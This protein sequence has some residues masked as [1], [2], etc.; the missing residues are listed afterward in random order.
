MNDSQIEETALMD[1]KSLDSIK[2]KKVSLEKGKLDVDKKGGEFFVILHGPKTGEVIYINKP[3]LTIGRDDKSDIV[4]KQ[5]L[6]SRNHA[7]IVTEGEEVSVIDLDS[8]NGTLL[9]NKSIKTAVLKDGDEIQMG[10]LILQFFQEKLSDDV[11][12]EAVVSEETEETTG[13][14]KIIFKECEVYFGENTKQFLDRQITAH[15]KKTPQT[16]DFPDI[17]DI[18]KW[19]KISASLYMDDESASDLVHNILEKGKG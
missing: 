15:V 6:V 4:D 5:D 2:E 18:T 19:I 16:I 1:R 14:Y 9:N 8:T 17:L 12:E 11:Q 13:F 7:K 10:N 3:E